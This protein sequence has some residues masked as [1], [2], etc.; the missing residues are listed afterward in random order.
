MSTHDYVNYPSRFSPLFIVFQV[1]SELP[2]A[3]F[4]LEFTESDCDVF[5][6]GKQPESALSD[7]PEVTPTGDGG[8]DDGDKEGGAGG[9][10]AVSMVVMGVLMLGQRWVV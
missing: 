2:D 8:D 1:N 4:G 6:E 5:F 9:P 7:E 10:A 3:D